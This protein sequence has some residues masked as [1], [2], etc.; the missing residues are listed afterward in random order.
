MILSKKSYLDQKLS[1]NAFTI[2]KSDEVELLGLI[3]GKELN[4]SKGND[5]LSCNTEYALRQIRKYLGL[6]KAKNIR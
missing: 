5:R 2:N 3:I 6:E 4:F 1:V